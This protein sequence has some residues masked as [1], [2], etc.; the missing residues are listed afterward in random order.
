MVPP[1]REHA[2]FA[3]LGGDG[4][5][6]ESG[7]DGQWYEFWDVIASAWSKPFGFFCLRWTAS[8]WPGVMIWA[9]VVPA[10]MIHAPFCLGVSGRPVDSV[11][12]PGT[13]IVVCI[14]ALA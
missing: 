1:V 5:R 13:A 2:A 14:R 11:V 6:A 3:D 12:P 4:V 10:S 7:T 8:Q 9:V